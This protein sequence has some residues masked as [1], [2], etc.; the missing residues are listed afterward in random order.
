[1]KTNDGT[2][3]VS[4]ADVK[5]AMDGMTFAGVTGNFTLDATGTP[6]KS[7]VIIEYV[8]D[9]DADTVTSKYVKTVG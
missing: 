6:E 5:A 4:G 7:A 1:M 8:Y 3:T 9:A 2:V